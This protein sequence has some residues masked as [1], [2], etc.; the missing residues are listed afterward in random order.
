M[1]TSVAVL[2]LRATSFTHPRFTY[3]S[4]ALRGCINVRG[5]P[6]RDVR[7]PVE[8]GSRAR[9]PQD[10]RAYRLPP[11]NI[12]IYWIVTGNLLFKLW[13]GVLSTQKPSRTSRVPVYTGTCIS[14]GGED[15]KTRRYA[16]A[17]RAGMGLAAGDG[18][19]RASHGALHL[20]TIGPHWASFLR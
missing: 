7:S 2:C 1:P 5:V 19:S 16:V 11:L 15:A 6:I 3:M 18:P 17:V 12:E 10:H 4:C 8:H 13:H 20:V 14:C 9:G